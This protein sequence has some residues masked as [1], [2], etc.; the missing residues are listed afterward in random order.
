MSV[1]KEQM[2]AKQ[3]KRQQRNKRGTNATNAG[4]ANWAEVHVDIIALLIA[5]ITE[6]GG[7]V[8]LGLTRDKGAYYIRIY[9]ND[10]PY[11]V[12]VSPNDNL[13]QEVL[14]ILKENE[15]DVTGLE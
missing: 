5:K 12:Y 1:V 14:N 6:K 3:A 11:S 10:D 15:C 9:L 2:A 7:A 13:W 8:M 4:R